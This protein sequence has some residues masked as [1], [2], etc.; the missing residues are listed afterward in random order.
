MTQ[1]TAVDG[2]PVGA[3]ARLMLDARY[4]HFTAMQ[5]RDRRVRGL[6]R[7]FERLEAA[8]RELFGAE[9]DRAAVLASIRAVLDGGVRDA[10]LRVNVVEYG[11]R[12]RVVAAA[13]P[14]HPP[15]KGP[16]H[17]TPVVYQRYLP[18]IKQSF[19]F[20][21]T[22]ILRQAAREG[23]DEALLTTADGLISEGAITNL[24]GFADGRLV[25]PDAPMLRGITMSLLQDLDVPQERRP[26]KVADLTGFDQ[27]FLCNS[28]GVMPVGGVDGVPLRQDAGLLARLTG[29]YE[30]VP[31]DPVD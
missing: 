4:G 24:G 18:H 8:N 21:Q 12:P 23:F 30:S 31:A 11:G 5:V 10:G 27:V 28:W 20:Q 15:L 29:H 6:D 3:E 1:R 26:L 7:H 13:Y 9:L 2:E 22:H 17:V 19:G 16:L 25:W 14:P